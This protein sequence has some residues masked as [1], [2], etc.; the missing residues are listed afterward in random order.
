MKQQIFQLQANAFLKRE[1]VERPASARELY[2]QAEG[3]GVEDWTLAIIEGQQKSR[4]GQRMQGHEFQDTEQGWTFRCLPNVV[5]VVQGSRDFDQG[6]SDL[7]GFAATAGDLLARWLETK[8]RRSIRLSLIVQEFLTELPDEAV[9][10]PSLIH[11]PRSFRQPAPAEWDC[12]FVGKHPRAF[13]TLDETTNSVLELKRAN[14]T[15]TAKEKGQDAPTSKQ[16]EGVSLQLDINTLAE[17]TDERF[18]GASVRAFL[19]SAA[20]W[21]RE[22]V[23]EVLAQVGGATTR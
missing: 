8:E 21:Q 17:H 12:R 1:P 16:L 15:L 9:L 2:R 23:D 10:A 18:D 4:P 20:H 3:L 6:L 14:F 13:G 11:L 22:L 19:S 7:E 5:T